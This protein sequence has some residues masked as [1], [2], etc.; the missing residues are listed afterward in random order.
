M[1]DIKILQ[2]STKKILFFLPS[3]YFF[4]SWLIFSIYFYTPHLFSITYFI[5]FISM[6]SFLLAFSNSPLL[7]Y[8]PTHIIICIDLI[9]FFYKLYTYSYIYACI[10]VERMFFLCFYI[11][12]IYVPTYKYYKVNVSIRFFRKTSNEFSLE[13][14]KILLWSFIWFSL[15]FMPIKFQLNEYD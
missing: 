14:I 4:L 10:H 12:F 13:L 5:L 9:S 2:L 8:L 7:S 3:R 1:G 15:I 6:F 11:Y